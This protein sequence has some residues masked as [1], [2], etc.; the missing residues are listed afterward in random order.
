MPGGPRFKNRHAFRNLRILVAIHAFERRAAV[1]NPSAIHS[2]LTMGSGASK[3]DTAALNDTALNALKEQNSALQSQLN[4]ASISEKRSQ[5]LLIASNQKAKQLEEALAHAKDLAARNVKVVS[6]R[7]GVN[8][9]S[10]RG[11]EA[12]FHP[13][14]AQLE[15]ASKTGKMASP[16]VVLNATTPRVSAVHAV[17]S[18]FVPPINTA[19]AAPSIKV[20][21]SS[22]FSNLAAASL[23]SRG[24]V[25]ARNQ[26]LRSVPGAT[27]SMLSERLISVPLVSNR[28][29]D[30][31]ST[32]LLR[33]ASSLQQR[34][35]REFSLKLQ[36]V[37]V[38]GGRSGFGAISA[39]ELR[40]F[41]HFVL[42]CHPHCIMLLSDADASRATSNARSPCDIECSVLPTA[43]F[44]TVS[45]AD[46]LND[47][48]SSI[49]S[50]KPS[51][52]LE[53]ALFTSRLFNSKRSC[54]LAPQKPSPVI[55]DYVLQVLEL[56]EAASVLPQQYLDRPAIFRLIEA[57]ILK[58]AASFPPI[59]N[60]APLWTESHLCRAFGRVF[61]EALSA[62][63]APF[64]RLLTSALEFGSSKIALIVSDAIDCDVALAAALFGK[65]GKFT[66]IQVPFLRSAAMDTCYR[67]CASLLQTIVAACSDDQNDSGMGLAARSLSTSPPSL[68]EV[69]WMPQLQRK[70]STQH[71]IV[72]SE[73]LS[74]EA[75]RF[76]NVTL[77]PGTAVV[78]MISAA[79]A[80]VQPMLGWKLIPCSFL[81][82]YERSSILQVLASF[83]FVFAGSAVSALPSKISCN[84]AHVAIQHA[85]SCAALA[86]PTSC[87]GEILMLTDSSDILVP[88]V[89]FIESVVD[90]TLS[91]GPLKNLFF[92][93]LLLCSLSWR[94]PSYQFML[95]FTGCAPFHLNML[96]QILD[97]FIIQA[98]GLYC[99]A[100]EILAKY[101]QH[102]FL[103][104]P[105]ESQRF[106]K[107]LFEFYWA[108]VFTS[109]DAALEVLYHSCASGSS[110]SIMQVI[111]S[112]D[113]LILL[114]SSTARPFLLSFLERAEASLGSQVRSG[115]IASCEA[116]LPSTKSSAINDASQDSIKGMAGNLSWADAQQF[117]EFCTADRARCCCFFLLHESCIAAPSFSSLKFDTAS[118]RADGKMILLS[119]SLLNFFLSKGNDGVIVP[120][121]AQFSCNVYLPWLFGPVCLRMLSLDA[122]SNAAHLLALRPFLSLCQSDMNK[123][124]YMQPSLFLFYARIAL[125]LGDAELSRN[126]IQML[127]NDVISWCELHLGPVHP[128]TVSAYALRSLHLMIIASVSDAASSIRQ[129]ISALRSIDSVPF[130]SKVL[131][132]A[133]SLPL[134]PNSSKSA[135]FTF[136]KDDSTSKDAVAY[137]LRGEWCWRIACIDVARAS[138]AL[139]MYRGES[140]D[141]LPLL[142]YCRSSCWSINWDDSL[143]SLSVP[144]LSLFLAFSSGRLDLAMQQIK[145][146]KVVSISDDIALDVRLWAGDI[147]SLDGALAG[148]SGSSISWRFRVLSLMPLCSDTNSALFKQL[149]I[150][151]MQALQASIGQNGMVDA[152]LYL[153]H[154][155]CACLIISQELDVAA[156][157]QASAVISRQYGSRHVFCILAQLAHAVALLSSGS[158][159]GARQVFSTTDGL[160]QSSMYPYSSC[161]FLM[162]CSIMSYWA[163]IPSLCSLAEASVLHLSSQIS[164]ANHPVLLYSISSFVSCAAALGKVDAVSEIVRQISNVHTESASAIGSETQP[165]S[166]QQICSVVCS[167]ANSFASGAVIAYQSKY[168][169]ALQLRLDSASFLSSAMHWWCQRHSGIHVGSDVAI[170]A[171][172][173]CFE[174]KVTNALSLFAA[175]VYLSGTIFSSIQTEISNLREVIELSHQRRQDAEPESGGILPALFLHAQVDTAISNGDVEAQGM[176]LVR[177]GAHAH[178]TNR[179]DNAVATSSIAIARIHCNRTSYFHAL[180]ATRVFADAKCMSFD[181]QLE[182]CLVV[183]E[184]ATDCS[185]LLLIRTC[186][187]CLETLKQTA[188]DSD[189]IFQIIYNCCCCMIF[190]SEDKFVAAQQAL[191][192]AKTLSASV[193]EQ[194]SLPVKLQYLLLCSSACMY[195]LRR[196]Y[197][198]AHECYVGLQSI[199]PDTHD[200]TISASVNAL[201]MQI[202]LSDLP[203]GV[204]V[205]KLDALSSLCTKFPNESSVFACLSRSRAFLLERS[206]EFD[207]SE[208]QFRS[209]VIKA[210]VGAFGSVNERLAWDHVCLGRLYMQRLQTSLAESALIDA[211]KIY[212]AIRGDQNSRI[213]LILFE[214]ASVYERYGSYSQAFDRACKSIKILDRIPREGHWSACEAYLGLGKFMLVIDN[215]SSSLEYLSMAAA[216][217]DDLQGPQAIAALESAA[218]AAFAEHL[219]SCDAESLRK[220][221]RRIFSVLSNIASAA[222][223]ASSVASSASKDSLNF[224]PSIEYAKWLS[225]VGACNIFS[226][227]AMAK[228]YIV[229]AKNICETFSSSVA[230][231]LEPLLILAYMLH[232]RYSKAATFITARIPPGL[233][234]DTGRRNA[235]NIGVEHADLLHAGAM[236]QYAICNYKYA[237]ELLRLSKAVLSNQTSEGLDWTQ[238]SV[239][240]F[241]IDAIETILCSET[242][243][244]LKTIDSAK[245]LLDRF[246]LG[247]NH[248]LHHILIA[249][250]IH[251]DIWKGCFS[252]A[253]K[254]VIMVAKD[255]RTS[256]KSSHMLNVRFA[257]LE[258]IVSIACGNHEH[259]I[260]SLDFCQSAMYSGWSLLNTA[261]P[262]GLGKMALFFMRV[263]RDAHAK[264][265]FGHRELCSCFAIRTFAF[266]FSGQFSEAEK[267]AALTQRCVA[268]VVNSMASVR[269]ETR[270][271]VF[272]SLSQLF[273]AMLQLLKGNSHDAFNACSTSVEGMV[274]SGWTS[275][276]L[277]VGLGRLLTALSAVMLGDTPKARLVASSMFDKLT[278]SSQSAGMLSSCMFT[279]VSAFSGAALA[280]ADIIS[281]L[282]PF[283][284]PSLNMPAHDDADALWSYPFVT[285]AGAV[286]CWV[287]CHTET[288]QKYTDASLRFLQHTQ[289]RGHPM[290]AFITPLSI[291]LSA[292][293]SS[294]SLSE[295]T[296]IRF[297]SSG[298]LVS[299][300]MR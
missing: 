103:K 268:A 9:P 157:A 51:S 93:V 294:D 286:A 37:D 239:K 245:I 265:G 16:R 241:R 279:I 126:A 202:V 111:G 152:A 156:F 236:L 187:R 15:V 19:A 36:I 244:S 75:R 94:G 233:L 192:C 119:C 72:L 79:D 159:S 114:A 137:L 145:I 264:L 234:V 260:R 176:L 67:N 204:L 90:V 219:I 30:S 158:I 242:G 66:A 237:S 273:I 54:L 272:V 284:H 287:S 197:Q 65:K 147:Q 17:P 240:M 86:L 172:R 165:S 173:A 218:Y 4:A 248:L 85:R 177:A 154:A 115:V 249:S 252:P 12:S 186:L 191:S 69:V 250:Q 142:A 68:G 6:P 160:L 190:A 59:S 181:I 144:S 170:L 1:L 290:H 200:L 216:G 277:W 48:I 64:D 14:S 281:Q 39:P 131:S 185:D 180:G 124:V 118:G 221:K 155:A 58:W 20:G 222:Q 97:G 63:A 271:T 130:E 82:G 32:E 223:P 35:Q 81:A 127:Q 253:S 149:H 207:K 55:T 229:T 45:H 199:Y 295:A 283:F 47:I 24:A 62:L 70:D 270:L 28:I 205:S 298:N 292:E 123:P 259:A 201:E 134:V 25:T 71:I 161:L 183:V 84:A 56:A 120:D 49:Q 7:V 128:F 198:L 162:Y 179:I 57:D 18:K 300:S 88:V 46:G 299:N 26:L 184:A 163:S 196:S 169:S 296:G 226:C 194:A 91:S 133:I 232:G 261:A 21:S 135:E 139:L 247:N 263:A 105:T 41:V 42:R 110:S 288:A 40:M 8:I 106:H 3:K 33:F 100:S 61:P 112:F 52:I 209:I 188:S 175:S 125:S 225:C 267:S 148:Q 193:S 276:N 211:F 143:G 2:I 5:E 38:F 23:S 231:T 166:M 60:L 92:D 73:S 278:S 164:N 13:Q 174:G 291:I 121:L 217:F 254:Q 255:M 297:D 11:D 210:D 167:A 87:L 189:V 109:Q 293:L 243:A 53:V 203:A 246:R 78:C 168:K 228:R 171:L 220:S 10:P 146:D 132:D 99:I 235:L 214:L 289:H 98:C 102:R 213:A 151:N 89:L 206:M 129:A 280:E 266:A 258:A 182:W 31:F 257:Q 83:G 108:I 269:E 96:L 113:L 43:F 101:F 150:Q 262:V 34:L 104:Q 285:A 22:S 140:S 44:T 27:P 77:S 138:A 195:Q 136:S 76:T 178:T 116:F 80:Q 153:V 141:A 251:S 215:W 212:R 208:E 227:N 256:Y 282:L 274:A 224:T 29:D 74:S 117:L 122:V 50:A 238:H 275:D 95:Q 230:A 107:S